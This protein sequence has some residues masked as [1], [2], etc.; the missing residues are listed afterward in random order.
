MNEQAFIR[1]MV[2]SLLSWCDDDI[3][4]LAQY[5]RISRQTIYRILSCKKI[6]SRNVHKIIYHYYASKD[7][8]S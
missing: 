7:R 8:T 5:L 3:K 6:S 2:V 4:Q 1:E